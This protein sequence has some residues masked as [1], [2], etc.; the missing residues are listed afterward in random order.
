MTGPSL[1]RPK[2]TRHRTSARAAER[3]DRIY[4]PRTSPVTT[5]GDVPLTQQAVRDFPAWTAPPP[6]T[7]A[8]PPEHADIEVLR[9]RVEA[10]AEKI[11]FLEHGVQQLIRR[12]F[13]NGIPLKD[14]S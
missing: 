13:G 11:A 2:R 8:P 7:P 14:D 1:D 3:D 12:V 10:Q 4:D 9:Q 5:D 6:P